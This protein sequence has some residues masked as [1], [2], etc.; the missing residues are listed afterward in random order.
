[1][2]RD[3]LLSIAI[4]IALIIGMGT[5]SWAADKVG[6][7]NLQRLVNESEMGKSARNDILKLRGE[8]EALL[9]DKLKEVNDLKDYINKEGNKMGPNEK[10]DQV[11]KFNRAY[12][13]YQRLLTDAREDIAN[14]D[15]NLVAIIL[16]KAD[17]ALKKVAKK[18]NYAIII[19]D[20]NAIGYLDP[21]VDI[22]DDVLK[23]L[24][25]KPQSSNVSGFPNR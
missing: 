20:P 16:Q 6:Y 24:N 9:R 10:R 19:K 2:R 11:Q 23:E 17:D 4:C 15:K 22:T 8:R 25:K 7:I 3:P 18:K 13:D 5:V 14:E 21:D 12:K 1:M